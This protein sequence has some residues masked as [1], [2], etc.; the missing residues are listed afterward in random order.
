M[1]KQEEFYTISIY[2]DENENLIG[3][4]CGKSKKYGVAD[5]DLS[6]IHI[7]EPTRH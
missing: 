6:L 4:P 1:K 2:I 5:I 3:I 7:S